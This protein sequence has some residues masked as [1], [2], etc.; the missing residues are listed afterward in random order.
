[1]W[2]LNSFK[3]NIVMT[4]RK[5]FVPLFGPEIYFISVKKVISVIGGGIL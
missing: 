1:M 2:V 5:Y 3:I 4:I